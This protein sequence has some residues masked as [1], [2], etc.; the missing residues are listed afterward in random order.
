MP[1]GIIQVGPGRLQVREGGGAVAVFG[2]PFL[3]AGACVS[4]ISAGLLPVDNAGDLPWFGRPML[5]F[6]G[7]CFTL[8][9]GTLVFGRR[10]TTF[11][12]TART[13]V[14]Q[15][16][17]LVPMST[18]THRIDDYTTVLLDFQ[19]GD[20]DTADQF[21]VSLRA[22]AGKHLRLFS[23]TEYGDARE[24]ATA[25]ASLLHLDIE[26][27]STDHSVTLSAAQAVLSLQQ[28][29]RLNVR[30]PSLSLALRTCEARSSAR[31]ARSA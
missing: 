26:D 27:A 12:A 9:G 1:R 4:L 30:I 13:I 16:G 5:L 24:R 31:T 14:K 20:S 18:T 25:I 11:D 17:L 29:L 28:R 8:V 22:R 15:M 3:I 7:L 10:W 23:S 2:L 6:M 19:R 21:P